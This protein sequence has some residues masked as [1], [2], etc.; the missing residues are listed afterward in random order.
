MTSEAMT[1]EE[2]RQVL[3]FVHRVEHLRWRKGFGLLPEGEYVGD[4][5]MPY[6][7]PSWALELARSGVPGSRWCPLLDPALADREEVQP[8][9]MT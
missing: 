5:W 2:H 6:A 4:C 9:A 3:H 7:V 1:W 8:W